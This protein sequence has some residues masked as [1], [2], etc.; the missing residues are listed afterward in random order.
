MQ[1]ILMTVTYILFKHIPPPVSSLPLPTGSI[2]FEEKEFF[3]MKLRTQLI[4][5]CLG[6]IYFLT[7]THAHMFMHLHTTG[8]WGQ[9]LEDKAEHR[10]M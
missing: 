2:N 5:W 3:C 1:C 6:E 10:A 4:I 8:E 7:R 9:N